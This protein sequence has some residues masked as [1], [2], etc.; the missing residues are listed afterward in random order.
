[1]TM[2]NSPAK[3]DHGLSPAQL[4][5]IKSILAHS[6]GAIER[7]A[8]FGSRA[9]AAYKSN[10]DIDLVIY[11]DINAQVAD[12]LWTLFND[13]ILPYK[14]DVN[15]YQNI[16]YQPL[17]AHIDANAKTLFTKRQLYAE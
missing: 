1:M 5:L 17:L 3:L 4:Q 2:K 7:V 9:C 12:R 10:S 11:G 16:R 8:L 15:I 13:S 6:G 14:V